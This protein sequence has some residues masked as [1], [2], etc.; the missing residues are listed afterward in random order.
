MGRNLTERDAEILSVLT[1]RVRVLSAEQLGRTWWKGCATPT[2]Q[3]TARMKTLEE[4]GLVISYRALAH[5]EIQ[6]PEPVIRWGPGD[7]EPAFGPASYRLQSRWTKPFVSTTCFVASKR[8]GRVSGGFGGRRSRTSEQ[9]HDIHL[10]AVFLRYRAAAPDLVPRWT[11][12]AAILR[13]RD[14][15]RGK[16][17]DAMVVDGDYCRIIEFGGSYGKKKI[18]A[19]HNHCLNEDIP[20]EIW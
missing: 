4:A 9:T 15:R 3:A 19:F 5:P 13:N 20:Y 8:A 10:S 7:Q 1:Q 14:H 6:L 2:Q 16:L 18:E 11:S 17:P 12:E